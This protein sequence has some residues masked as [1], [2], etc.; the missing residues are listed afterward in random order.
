MTIAVLG[1]SG[2]L[3]RKTIQAIL[4]RGTA[5]DLVV[6]AVRTPSN[7]ADLIAKDVQVKAADYDDPGSMTS[8]FAGSERVLLVPSTAPPRRAASISLRR[9]APRASRRR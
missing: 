1:A 2:Q 8:A 3:G 6:A 5:A 7:A 4:A 9:A